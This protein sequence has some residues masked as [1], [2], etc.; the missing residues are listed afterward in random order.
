MAAEQV[1][2]WTATLLRGWGLRVQVGRTHWSVRLWPWAWEWEQSLMAPR[3][4]GLG[5]WITRDRWAGL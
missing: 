4:Y 1:R 5:F 3:L 2:R